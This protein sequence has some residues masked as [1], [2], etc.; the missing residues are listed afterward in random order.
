MP[1]HSTTCDI[2]G[3]A[4]QVVNINRMSA[5]FIFLVAASSL[6]TSHRSTQT[7]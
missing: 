1:C 7:V 3:N 4:A 2:A 6:L 5:L